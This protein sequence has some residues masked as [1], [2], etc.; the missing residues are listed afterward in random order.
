MTKKKTY[1]KMY[2][3]GMLVVLL[4]FSCVPTQKAIRDANIEVP[5]HYQ[6]TT[7]DT[8]NVAT[9]RWKDFFTDSK[10]VALIDTALANNQELHIILQRIAMANNE[11]K[12]RKGEY[13]PFVNVYAGAEVEKV[14]EYTRNGAVEQQLDI[15]E[16]EEFPEPLT[17]FSVGLD[18]SWELDVWK[19]L[20][21]GKKAAVLEYL[22]TIEGKNFMVTQLVSE[23]ANS[24]YELL[25]LDNQL[26]I[27]EQNLELQNNALDMVK[28]QKQAARATQLAVKRFEAE[29]LKNQSNKFEIQQQ[30]VEIENKINFLLGRYPQTIDR[31][32]SDFIARPIDDIEAGLPAQLLAN[33]PDIKQAEYELEALKLNVKM[34]KANFYPSIGIKAGIGLQAF[35]SKYLTSTPESLL[36]S[37]VGDVVSP[38]INRNAI[39]A[40]YSNANSRQLQAVFEYE[41]AILNGYIEVANTLSDIKNLKANYNLKTKQVAAMTEAIDLSIQLFKSARAEYTEVLMT[42]R[43]ALD[44]KLEI[45]ETKR[46][47][48]LAN[49]KIYQALG[50]GW[51]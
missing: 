25:A 22:S 12:V 35:N 37:L 15:R 44:S 18:V 2:F 46:D 4:A 49:V 23:I 32:A 20:R 3:I 21:N 27:I 6:K 29:V 19:K 11:V 51:N 36:Y 40:A 1:N 30:I 45:I 28:L 24:Y 7:S 16:G 14:G 31:D 38:L 42:Q 8:S 41:K 34:A 39:K 33:R 9:L 10:L 43:E 13:L 50:G 47:Q 26:Q 5:E 17:D 48:Y